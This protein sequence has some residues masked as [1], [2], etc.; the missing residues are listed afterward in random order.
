MP[1]LFEIKT[2]QQ[3]FQQENSSKLSRR[4][5]GEMLETRGIETRGI[6]TRG[7]GGHLKLFERTKSALFVMKGTLF[8]QT[9]I[10]ANTNLTSKVPFVFPQH[11]CVCSCMLPPPLVFYASY[12]PVGGSNGSNMH[13][14]N[15]FCVTHQD[16]CQ[17]VCSTCF[18]SWV[19][20][21]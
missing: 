18:I 7:G 17:K 1:N 9:N 21:I 3:T 2:K 16:Y 12:G 5:Q 13:L 8:V 20:Y 6:G 15:F 14:V 4:D 11:I 10:P 19:A